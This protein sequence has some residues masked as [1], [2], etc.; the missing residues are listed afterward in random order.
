MWPNNGTAPWADTARLRDLAATQY[1]QAKARGLLSRYYDTPSE[2]PNLRDIV[3]RV[4]V[5]R[6]VDMGVLNM[7]DMEIVR[8]RARGWG[9][10]KQ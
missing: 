6:D 9:S 10:I 5:G 8:D 7:D 4:L 2:P 3:C 1:D